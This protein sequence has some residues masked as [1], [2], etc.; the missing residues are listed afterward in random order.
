MIT[1]IK[2]KQIKVVAYHRKNYCG[3]TV[4]LYWHALNTNSA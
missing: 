3:A 1:I 2:H 4:V